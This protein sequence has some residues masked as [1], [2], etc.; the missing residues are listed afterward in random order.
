[1][2]SEETSGIIMQPFSDMRLVKSA[3][4]EDGSWKFAGIA[5]DET[6][7]ADGEVILRKAIDLSYAQERGYVNW[8]HSKSPAD[9]IGYLTKCVMVDEPL[10]DEL[11]KSLGTEVKK[12]ATVYV[13]GALYPTVPRAQEVQNIMKSM[14]LTYGGL[15]LS[16][17]GS[18]AK[19]GK[20]ITRAIVRGVAFTPYPAHTK[21]LVTLAKSILASQ[22][23]A[24]LTDDEAV[25]FV[26]RKMPHWTYDIASRVV[27]YTKSKA[28]GA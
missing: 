25:L 27:Q 28:Q 5:S 21:T 17:E 26:L 8:N 23:T 15:G 12:T 22:D 9:Q 4:G 3:E 6:E 11:S 18:L 13:E 24:F 14:P 1:M 2:S 20:R 7:D 10:R 19:A 16:V